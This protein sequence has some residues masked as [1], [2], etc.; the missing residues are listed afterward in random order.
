[1]NTKS[2]PFH[3]TSADISAIMK[4][5]KTVKQHFTTKFGWLKYIRKWQNYAVS[6]NTARVSLR[7]RVM[8]NWLRA[9]GFTE[10]SEWP[11]ALQFNSRL[12]AYRFVPQILSTIDHQRHGCGPFLGLFAHRFCGHTCVAD[13]YILLE[14]FLHFFFSSSALGCQRTE[15]SW[16]LPLVRKWAG[17]STAGFNLVVL[18]VPFVL[19]VVIIY[20]IQFRQ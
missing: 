7:S 12:K 17:R 19:N 14:L 2:S 15:L 9:N 8:H 13:H 16:I 4:F 5:Y 18:L 20:H 6:T 10:K 11:Q 1:M 3:A